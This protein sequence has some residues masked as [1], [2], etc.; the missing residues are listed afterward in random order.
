MNESIIKPTTV[1]TPFS[2]RVEIQMFGRPINWSL[3]NIRTEDDWNDNPILRDNLMGLALK[4][5][6]WD[7]FC[8]DISKFNATICCHSDLIVTIPLLGDLNPKLWRGFDAEGIILPEPNGTHAQHPF[9]FKTAEGAFFSTAD[10]AVVVLHSPMTGKTVAF[11][12]GRD[13]LIE[14][15]FIMTGKH[16]REFAS[17]VDAAVAQFD[18]TELPV[19]RAFICG[20]ASNLVQPLDNPEH[21]GYNLRL[22]EHMAIHYPTA[23]TISNRKLFLSV[24]ELIEQQLIARSISPSNIGTDCAD[25]LSDRSKN[26][27][28]LWWSHQR[29]FQSGQSGPDGR[30]GILVIRKW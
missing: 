17:V 6:V 29:W 15:S 16:E 21:A 14:R 9:D 30:N 2:G 20:T 25:V 3:K 27:E 8:P 26:G 5:S 22:S 12:A 23:I 1:F 28:Y 10:C 7:M 13:S 11:H 18:D 4:T 19:M 24:T